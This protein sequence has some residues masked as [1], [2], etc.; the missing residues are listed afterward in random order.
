MKDY[1][2]VLYKADIYPIFPTG[3]YKNVLERPF[4]KSEMKFCLGQ[5]KIK[6]RV[7][8]IQKIFLF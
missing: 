6:T 4:S 2:T 1:K 3:V 5:E 8:V 7:T